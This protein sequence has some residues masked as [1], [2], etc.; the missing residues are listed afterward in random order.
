MGSREISDQQIS[1][2]TEFSASH[3]AIYGRLNFKHDPIANPQWK[4]GGW[5]ARVNDGNQ[6]LQIELDS[7]YTRVKR[8]ATQG[9]NV[10]SQWVIKYKLQYSSDGVNFQYYKEKGQA[11]SKVKEP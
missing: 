9:R 5:S 10:H 2:S 1:A 7:P 3:A 6:W 4:S 11:A 8:V